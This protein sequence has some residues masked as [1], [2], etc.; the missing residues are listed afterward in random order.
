M[1]LVSHELY[2][3]DARGFEITIV[4]LIALALWRALPP[5]QHPPVYRALVLAWLGIGT[6]SIL[7]A[8]EPLYAGFGAWRL[9]RMTVFAF[10]LGRACEQKNVPPVVLQGLACGLVVQ[11]FYALWDRYVGGQYQADGSFPHQNSL[12]MAANLVIPICFALVLGK[13]TQKRL[14]AAAMAAGIVC[15]V[16]TLSRG[17]LVM[18]P[19]ALGLV[20]VGSLVREPTSRKLKIGAVG[21]LLV[22]IGSVKAVDTIVERF[23]YAP[24][25]SEVSRERF[26]DAAAA[27]LTDH[28][29]GVGM[30]NYSWALEHE[31]ATRFDV[32]DVDRSGIVHNVYWL[33]LAETGYLGLLA[34]GLLTL[35]PIA[36]G[37][38]WFKRA[39][40]NPRGDVILGCT[41]A[42]VVTALQGVLEWL[43]R[44]TLVSYLVWIL[45]VVIIAL[46]RQLREER[47][48]AG[49]V[50]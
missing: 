31:Y 36:I 30:N 1:N 40:P 16:L 3:G 11:M 14:A 19:V 10:V 6:L 25:A 34:Y 46:A 20:Y 21:A 43:A 8:W 26:E 49:T 33:S 35:A 17:A 9:A 38:T 29:F 7:W 15:V 22:A 23:L 28:P 50:R 47:L 39:G 48:L 18:L 12:G 42:L 41:V 2:R 45:A 32:A 44:Q 5:R 4:D 13:G 37:V 24:E 27:M